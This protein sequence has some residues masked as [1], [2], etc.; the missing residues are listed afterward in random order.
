[1]STVAAA[2]AVAGVAL[3][4]ASSAVLPF[5][6]AAKAEVEPGLRLDV[7]PLVAVATSSFVGLVL[8]SAWVGARTMR[9]ASRSGHI[10]AA[11]RLT[12]SAARAGLPVG[13]V[14]G[15]SQLGH[16]RGRT[17]VRSSLGAVTFALAAVVAVAIYATT[18][19]RFVY[20]PQEHGWSWDLVVGDSDDETLH[21]VGEQL[22]GGDADI[23]GFA[24]VWSGQEDVVVA[25]DGSSAAI[26]A[27]D[28]IAGDTYVQLHDGRPAQR[29]DEVVV[30]ARTMEGLGVEVG[31]RVTF[32]GNE[33][34]AT[35]EVVGTAV[36]HQVLT[37]E[38]ELDEGAITTRGGLERL[39]G[40]ELQLDR[41]IVDIADGADQAAVMDALRAD[42]GPTVT[43]H[44]PPLDVASLRGTQRL[45]VLLGSVIGIVGAGSLVHL[46]LVTVRR[47]RA[48][49]AV[50]RALGA[51]R[52]Q[53]SVAI[54]SMASI[55][56][57]LAAL[58]GVPAG[59]VLG[60]AAWQILA[61]SV[62]AP[63]A[64]V[65]PL[66]AI[67]GG[68]LAVVLAANAIAA[69]PGRVI[70]RMRPADALRSE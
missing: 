11:G 4:Y 29:A 59:V 28:P 48:Q 13:M 46:L 56:V 62:G 55:A 6:T 58:V 7:L 2:G 60:R 39:F 57:V 66:V 69:V 1:M 40:P 30:G 23:T 54:A 14:V 18:T 36:L 34:R 22:L 65:V 8:W 26:T 42:F 68:V 32:E 17:P 47:R 49:F 31:D 45:P 38:F 41:F 25:S 21:T 9:T 5:G 35:F 51:V 3:G 44:V 63:T 70:R 12:S 43:S 27:V 53:L 10:G 61:D 50:L 64:P 24:S 15:L 16:G 52:S 33:G 67:A 20:Q 19:D 37:D